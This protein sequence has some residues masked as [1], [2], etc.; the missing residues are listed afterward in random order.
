MTAQRMEDIPYSG[1]R[2]IFSECN[3]LEQAGKDIIH[4]EIGRPDFDTPISN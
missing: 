4:L 1:I 2:E 3:R